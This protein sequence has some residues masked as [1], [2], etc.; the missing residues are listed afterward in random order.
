[1]DVAARF[2]VA[3]ILLAAAAAKVRSR[4]ELP[5]LLAPYGVPA[6]LRTGFGLTLA[7]VEAALAL[8]LLAG[9]LV[10]PASFAALGLGVVFT[11]ALARVRVSGATRIRCGCFGAKERSTTF[12]IS[13][14]LVFTVLAGIAAFGGELSVETPSGDTVVLGSLAILT[15][16][17]IV[18]AA[19]VLALYR[20]VGVLSLRIGPR[21]ALELAEEGP[22]VGA[23][24]PPLNGLS[25]RGSELV[26][27][28]SD[29]CRLCR[30]LAPAVRALGR[31][32]LQVRVVSERDEAPEFTRWN[33]PGTP[34]VVHLVDGVVAA[35]GLV[36]T[37]EQLDDLVALGSARRQHAAA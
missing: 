15:V 1:M 14:A 22:D 12:L 35:K 29:N 26:A 25:R 8:L 3:L 17:V 30:E 4:A 20:Q 23:I 28:F 13:R 24:A 31:E 33:I 21:A 34:F 19:L 27:F 2:A 11:L 37:L 10:R 36:N 7:A 6:R 5:D 32:G 16:A 9:I 18:L